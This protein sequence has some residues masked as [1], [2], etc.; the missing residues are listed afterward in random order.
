MRKLVLA[1]VVALG[2][3]L[4]F[5]AAAQA[6]SVTIGVGND[7]VRATEHH[8]RHWRHDHWRHRH[9][10]WTKRVVHY[11]HHRRVVKTTRVCN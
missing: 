7:G 8:H 11:H 9:H 10:C 1:S 4:S 6:A 3:S 2:A 5:G